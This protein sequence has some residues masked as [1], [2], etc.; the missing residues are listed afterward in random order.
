MDKR[1][2]DIL[3]LPEF[4]VSMAIIAVVIVFPRFLIDF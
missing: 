3:K 4:G 2:S 1:V